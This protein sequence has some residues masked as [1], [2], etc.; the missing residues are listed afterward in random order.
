MKGKS[1][2]CVQ[3]FA[4]PWTTAHQAPLSMGFSRQGYWSGVPLPCLEAFLE[5]KLVLKSSWTG[6]KMW[7]GRAPCASTVRRSPVRENV[8]CLWPLRRGAG[9]LEGALSLHSIHGLIPSKEHASLTQTGRTISGGQDLQGPVPR[10]AFQPLQDSSAPTKEAHPFLL[11]A[12]PRPALSLGCA[13]SVSSV[14]S[15]SPPVPQIVFGRKLPS[16]R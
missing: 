12:T 9:K 5:P 4:T 3:L 11:P 6:G 16:P 13:F 14:T 2:S 7:S 10:G 1:L 15:S 8:G